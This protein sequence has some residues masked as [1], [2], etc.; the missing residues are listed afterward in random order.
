[1]TEWYV[2]RLLLDIEHWSCAEPVR[3]LHD[4]SR[5]LPTADLVTDVSEAAAGSRAASH[6]F[7]ALGPVE[8]TR[9]I[10]ETDTGSG[11]GEVVSTRQM[12]LGEK[13]KILTTVLTVQNASGEKKGYEFFF[14]Q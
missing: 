4:R 8:G 1:M 7:G 14:R 6:G 10:V 3:Q 9:L 2:P 11:T 13:A 5:R 12:I